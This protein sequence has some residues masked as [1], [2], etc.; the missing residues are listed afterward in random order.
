[1]T[2]ENRRSNIAQEL[3]RAKECLTSADLLFSHGQ[4]SDAVSRLYYYLYHA[5]RALLLSKGLEPKTHEGT[6]RLLSMHFVKTGLLN[7]E[8]SHI[9]TRLMKYREEA[10]YNPSY[11]FTQN[12]YE[13][14]RKEAEAFH[15]R[16]VEFLGD[17]KLL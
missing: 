6:L 3:A 16:V 17:E 10:D 1:M 15:A 7:V 5:V 11:S 4:L 12:D 9:F 13:R 2:Q 14:F 8:T